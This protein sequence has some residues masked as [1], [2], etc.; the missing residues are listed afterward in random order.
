MGVAVNIIAL[1]DHA[2]NHDD[3]AFAQGIVATPVPVF[4]SRSQT[5]RFRW[6]RSRCRDWIWQTA[7]LP[8]DSKLFLTST[9][10]L[11][12]PAVS[13]SIALKSSHFDL[14]SKVWYPKSL[15]PFFTSVML[16]N[17]NVCCND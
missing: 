6:D 12:H 9:W 4:G 13:L 7:F 16:T 14:K 1:A 11:I 17:V 2:R 5:T 10:E 15:S 3:F 8:S